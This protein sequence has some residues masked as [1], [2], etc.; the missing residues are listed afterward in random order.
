M[1]SPVPR[2]TFIKM[3]CH[4]QCTQH[5]LNQGSIVD[6]DSCQGIALHSVMDAIPIHIP[7]PTSFIFM[8]HQLTHKHLTQREQT[9]PEH[10]VNASGLDVHVHVKWCFWKQQTQR[11]Y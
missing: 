2:I 4:L 6:E 10:E 9:R 3:T 8:S 5:A 11:E 7:T 1:N